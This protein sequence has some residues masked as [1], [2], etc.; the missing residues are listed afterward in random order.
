MSEILWS[1]LGLVAPLQ[2]RVLGL[3]PQGVTGI[4]IDTRSLQPGDLFFA[5]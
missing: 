2:A 1:G 3:P 4:S 5:I